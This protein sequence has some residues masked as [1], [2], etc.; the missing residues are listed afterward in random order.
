MSIEVAGEP[1]VVRGDPTWIRQIVTNLVANA[2]RHA[3]SRILVTTT[4]SGAR[5]RLA[6]ADDGAG[7]PPELL[8]RAFDRFTR[9]DGAAQP[10]RGAPGSASRS[11]L[12]SPTPS[13]AW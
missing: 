3:R 13:A 5:G 11:W 9:G 1:L 7:F 2:D 4:R 6:V 10:S 12:R 8:P